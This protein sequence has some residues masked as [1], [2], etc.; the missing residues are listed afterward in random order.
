VLH[1]IG[2]VYQ[3]VGRDTALACPALGMSCSHL[4]P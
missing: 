2:G 4:N 3:L 1:I